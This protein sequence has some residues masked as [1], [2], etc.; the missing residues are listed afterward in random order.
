MDSEEKNVQQQ[1]DGIV[2]LIL[3]ESMA[4]DEQL[5]KI[6]FDSSSDDE[7]ENA[8]RRGNALNMERGFLEA[9]Y[10]M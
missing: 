8:G 9:Y 10:N 2:H 3:E 4:I 1:Q 6:F 5:M 7:M